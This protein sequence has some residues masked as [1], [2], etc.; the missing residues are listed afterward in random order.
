MIGECR[1]DEAKVFCNAYQKLDGR[2]EQN[3][4]GH[5]A[6]YGDQRPDLVSEDAV[7]RKDDDARAGITRKSNKH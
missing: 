4:C 6:S 7:P 3:P 5:G 2:K 1:H